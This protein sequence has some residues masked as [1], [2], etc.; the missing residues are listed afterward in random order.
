MRPF[1]VSG[2]RST[3]PCIAATIAVVMAA[4][5]AAGAQVTEKPVPF[6][7][8][9]NVRSITPSL[10]SRLKLTAPAWP[11]TGEFEEARL[12]SSSSGLYVITVLH[13]DRSIDR[14]PL[15][16]AQR[17]AL[18]S[19]IIDGMSQVGRLVGEEGP[20]VVSEPAKTP[21]I[22]NQVILSAL[23]YAPAAAA[24]T[25][26]ASAGAGVYLLT[27]GASFFYLANLSRHVTVTRAQNHLATDGAIRGSLIVG[28]T[29][30]ALGIEP[31]VDWGAASTLIGGIGGSM[32]GYYWGRR[33]TDSEAHS[34]TV[35]STFLA[36]T[37]AGIVGSLGGFDHDPDGR[38]VSATLVSGAL[39]GYPLGLQYPRRAHY[40]VTAG[41]VNLIP[42]S[43]LLALGI[44]GTPLI[45]SHMDNH[46]IGGILTAGFVAGTIVGD[47][48]FV[49]P[50]DHSENDA[51]LVSLGAL[52][53]GLM[54]AAVP[55]IAQSDD[56]HF[57]LGSI[58]I[59]AL[60][61]TVGAE[62]LVEPRRA[63]ALSAR[64]GQRRG[65]AS[66]EVN[67]L[68]LV[69]AAMQRPGVYQIVS[70]RF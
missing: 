24:L 28:G 61:G 4:A 47:R 6:D 55:A 60:L 65:G 10:A 26:N 63:G 69:G 23:I 53:G 41:D 20:A 68:G 52:A 3:V 35:G 56:G 37:T 13:H 57:I 51:T 58:T 64:V 42:L 17:A 70:L 32:V 21:F 67:P 19:Q 12:Y 27:T 62:H 39:V 7:S 18:R 5:S 50:F 43:Q 25:H 16:E 8:I 44:V 34:Q 59:G 40:T 33:L 9:G 2:P 36:A 66:L 38:T 14:Y 46:A 29:L 48:A 54:G 15:D 22:R 11:V 49:R 45:D 1:F 31:N 30:N